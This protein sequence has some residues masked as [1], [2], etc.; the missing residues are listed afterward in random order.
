VPIGDA[1]HVLARVVLAVADLSLPP[2]HPMAFVNNCVLVQ[3][4]RPG[5]SDFGAAAPWVNGVFLAYK[6]R[7]AKRL[8]FERVGRLPLRRDEVEFPCWLVD[9]SRRGALFCRGELLWPVKAPDPREFLRR[10]DVRL[11]P[12]YPAQLGESLRRLQDGHAVA[13]RVL[14]IPGSDVRYHP[15]RDDILREAGVDLSEPY[16]K[17]I[18][19]LGSTRVDAYTRAT[20]TG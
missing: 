1:D 17:A 16:W 19:R 2:E 18:E 12:K 3:V 10:W 4:S 6:P 20:G 5:E 14:G 8:G 11:S 13:G 15:K 9:D 7:E